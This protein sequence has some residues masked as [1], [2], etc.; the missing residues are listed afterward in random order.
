MDWFANP[1]ILYPLLLL[2]YVGL[3]LLASFGLYKLFQTMKRGRGID[4]DSMPKLTQ[5]TTKNLPKTVID[6]VQSI[7]QKAKKLLGYYDSKQI[8]DE[9]IMGENQFLV[10]KILN[11]DLPE[12]VQNYQ[13]LDNVRANQL[14]VGT[15][16]KTAKVLLDEYLDTINEQFDDMLDAMYE[17]NAQKLLISNRYLKARFDTQGGDSE[18]VLIANTPQ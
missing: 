17:Q 6:K 13:R 10:K 18:L 8:K 7:D 4:F 3:P 16:G 1:L 2:I 14:A 5:V 15:T 9:A 11:E 12:A